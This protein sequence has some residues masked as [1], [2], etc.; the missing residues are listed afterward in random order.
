M[1]RHAKDNGG[2][3][4]DAPIGTHLAICVGLIDLGTQHG[5]Y[6]GKPN[7]RNQVFIR[8]ELVNEHMDDGAPFVVGAFLTNS[9]GE[10]A[11]M[12]HWLEN[13]RGK[14]FTLEE[15]DSFDLENVLGKPCM[16]TVIAK[17]NGK[18]G[19]KI[20]GVTAIPKGTPKPDKAENELF[21]FWIEE[22]DA[23]KFET[24]SDGLKKII[25]KSDEYIDM[26]STTQ[27]AAAARRGG[28]ASFDDMDDDIP[29]MQ[30]YHG[31]LWRVV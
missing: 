25:Q 3:F 13:W 7:A 21:S 16:V 22:W 26:H 11:N 23:Q 12:R 6:Q 20:G 24:I 15:L 1:G 8:F 28:G 14:P 17:G 9:L 19:I 4:Q 27:P 29:F 18:D 10:K 30:P 5:E 2:D 31:G